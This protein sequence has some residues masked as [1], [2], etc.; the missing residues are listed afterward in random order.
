MTLVY[1][2]SFSDNGAL[3]GANEVSPDGPVMHALIMGIG[4]FSKLP[5]A[6]DANRQACADSAR[7][8]TAFLIEQSE[9]GNLEAPLASI[10]C[11]ISDP[12][13]PQGAEDQLAQTH[14][15]CDPRPDTNVNS[16]I[17][18]NV[19]QACTDWLTR[20]RREDKTLPRPGDH[21]LLYIC[22][23]GVAGRDHGA[24][25]VLED[26]DPGGFNSWSELL[27][28]GSMARYIPA[29][30]KAGAVWIFLDACQEVLDEL[31]DKVGGP[32]VFRPVTLDVREMTSCLLY[33]SPSPRDR[34]KSRMPS[35]A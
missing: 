17:I 12:S 24:L 30:C 11:L 32:N 28:V 2:R 14:P 18:N 15:L 9:A 33:T 29:K 3:P 20:C 7:A 21:L 25:A 10:E 26:V 19:S 27:D 22:S 4:R 1:Q 8:M 6:R 16:G 35:S 34:Q 31:K 5:P 23:H 13:A